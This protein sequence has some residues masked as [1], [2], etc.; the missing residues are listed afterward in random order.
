MCR[1]CEHR[2]SVRGCSGQIVKIK[3]KTGKNNLEGSE[4][5]RGQKKGETGRPSEKTRP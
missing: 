1:A 5:R 3:K 2:E 4:K